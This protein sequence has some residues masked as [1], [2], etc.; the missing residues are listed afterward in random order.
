MNTKKLVILLFI[1]ATTLLFGAPL[2]AF[3][4]FLFTYSLLWRPFQISGVAMAPNYVN[5]QYYMATIANRSTSIQ[6][7]DVVVFRAPPSHDKN[8]LKRIIGLPKEKVLI[9]GGNVYINDVLLDETK[10]L[11][12]KGT[13][14]AGE[15]L[16]ENKEVIVPEDSYFVLGDNRAYSSDSRSWGFISRRDIIGELSFCY[17]KCNPSSY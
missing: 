16:A 1:G 10:Y 2:L 6:R 11:S 8:F 12:N 9:R 15:F 13:T 17:Y 14:H 3:G 7:G 5:G 4:I